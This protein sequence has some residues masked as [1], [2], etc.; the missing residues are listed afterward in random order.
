MYYYH[1]IIIIDEQLFHKGKNNGFV[2]LRGKG[3]EQV[4]KFLEDFHGKHLQTII[5]HVI[6]IKSNDLTKDS[7]EAV[8]RAFELLV[9]YFKHK[10]IN[11]KILISF[12]LQKVDNIRFNENLDR[13]TRLLRNVCN[14]NN[15]SYIANNNLSDE[16]FRK[17]GLHLNRKG[18]SFLV[19]NL[20]NQ[21]RGFKPREQ[22]ESKGSKETCMDF[23]EMMTVQITH[24]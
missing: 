10:F 19:G 16:C 14:K 13:L 1:I 21:L 17:D 24:Y 23:Q 2:S 9:E 20:K 7:P 8:Y 3:I 5:I 22:R 12:L 6:K 15:V 11:S 18:T 4:R